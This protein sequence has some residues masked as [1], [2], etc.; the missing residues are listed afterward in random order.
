MQ[1]AVLWL[2][3]ILSL[4]LGCLGEDFAKLCGNNRWTT[5]VTKKECQTK[6]EKFGFRGDFRNKRVGSVAKLCC[7]KFDYN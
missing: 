7:C 4:G 3:I 2:T 5:A 1:I 6:C